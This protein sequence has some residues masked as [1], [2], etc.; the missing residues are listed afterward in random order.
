[1]SNANMQKKMHVSE[2]CVSADLSRVLKTLLQLCALSICGPQVSC[3]IPKQR[4]DITMKSSSTCPKLRSRG[5]GRRAGATCLGMAPLP[6]PISS[7]TASHSPKPSLRNPHG[8][9]QIKGTL[10]YL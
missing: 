7:K 9:L 2:A 8:S 3:S 6:V 1:M 10:F 4:S 5:V